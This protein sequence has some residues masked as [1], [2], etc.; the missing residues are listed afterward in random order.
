MT[1]FVFNLYLNR[2]GKIHPGMRS[3]SVI[4]ENVSQDDLNILTVTLFS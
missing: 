1:F 3:R 2:K 4:R